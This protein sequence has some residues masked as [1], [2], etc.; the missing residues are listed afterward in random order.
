MAKLDESTLEAVSNSN[1]KTIG[2]AGAFYQAQAM[3]NHVQSQNR[4]GILAE[5]AIGAVIKNM[6]EV[7]PVQALSLVKA[8]TG[9]DLAAQLAQLIAALGANQQS[10]KVAQT[11]PP[12]THPKDVK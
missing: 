10:A 6:N 5:S 7:D 9:N 2:E 4:L 12:I 3:G 8:N 1:Y 11:T